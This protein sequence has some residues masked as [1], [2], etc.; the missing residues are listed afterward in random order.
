MPVAISIEQMRSELQRELGM[1]RVVYPRWVRQGKK[2]SEQAATQIERMEAVLEALEELALAR[3]VTEAVLRASLVEGEGA[4]QFIFSDGRDARLFVSAVE[5][6]R[7][8]RKAPLTLG[9]RGG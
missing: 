9:Q 1:R 8:P 2:S 4:V 7:L 3:H 6:L 5:S